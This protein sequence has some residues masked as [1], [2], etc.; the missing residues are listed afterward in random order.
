MWVLLSLIFPVFLLS[1]HELLLDDL[2][3]KYAASEELYHK[4]KRESAGHVVVYSRS[5]LERM[6]AH[7]LQDVLKTIRTFTLQIDRGGKVAFTKAGKS[8]NAAAPVKLYID[9]YEVLSATQNNAFSAYGD[10]DLYFIDHI[11]VYQGGSAIATGNEAGSIVIR[12]Y[13]KDAARENASSVALS[14]NTQG[15]GNLR[16]VD[17]GMVGDYAYLFYASAA[18]N[19]HETYE[20]N[21]QELSRDGVRQQF[22]FKLSQKDNFDFEIDGI[23]NRSDIFNGFGS[24]PTG[25]HSKRSNGYINAVK[26]FENDLRVALNMSIEDLEVHN[27][28]AIGI[29]LPNDKLIHDLYTSFY[30]RSYKALVEKKIV[31]GHNDLL[32]G[33]QWVRKEFDIKSYKHDS[34]EV[35]ILGPTQLDIAMVYMED[36]YSINESHL[37]AFSAKYDYYNNN[38]SQNAHEYSL[39]FGYTAL[40]DEAWT[41][42]LFGVRRYQYPSFYQSTFSPFSN[43]NLQSAK[44]LSATTEIIYEYNHHSKIYVGLGHLYSRDSILLNRETNQFE[45]ATS[46]GEFQRIYMRVEHRFDIDNKATIEW[47]KIHRENYNSPGSGMLLQLFNRVGK[48]DIYNE[49]VYRSGY[50]TMGIVVDRGY[51]YSLS[52]GYSF[53]KKLLCKVKGENL[54]DRASSV[55]VGTLEIPVVDRRG[56]IT[57]EYTF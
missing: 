22:H 52:V 1:A 18:K 21:A 24:A 45:N 4:T 12:L 57:L 7:T 30:G 9:D 28:D 23:H 11:E 47:Y 27:S 19:R 14:I 10:M 25:D 50:T 32:V 16:A 38:L 15:S 17:A 49:L 51:D 43:S 55:P 35:N 36:L 26:Y 46:S 39:R 29:I 40:F 44:I 13:T 2:L 37:L 42:K 54:L 6:Q 41:I 33:L 53:G 31:S 20:R 5:D 56:T 48:L 34:V 8:L 3:K